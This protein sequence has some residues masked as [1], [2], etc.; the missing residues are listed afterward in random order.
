[1]DYTVSHQTRF[2]VLT[3]RLPST[4]YLCIV[5]T[6]YLV[7]IAVTKDRDLLRL[8]QR[9]G[10]NL[11]NYIVIKTYKQSG[12]MGLWEHVC[13]FYFDVDFHTH[14]IIIFNLYQILQ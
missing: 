12:L 7:D 5:C 14:I 2:T 3:T 8:Q 1:M 4:K 9:R 13:E 11:T 10:E 6:E